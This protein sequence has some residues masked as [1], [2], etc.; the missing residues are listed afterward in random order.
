MRM[1]RSHYRLIEEKLV[2]F[3][4]ELDRKDKIKQMDKI[5]RIYGQN[6]KSSLEKVSV[7]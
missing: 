7:S 4:S 5:D 3:A 6:D 1:K 2:N